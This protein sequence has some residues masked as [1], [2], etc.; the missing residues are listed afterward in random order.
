[1]RPR[2]ILALALLLVAQEAAAEP[3]IE[4]FQVA[5]QERDLLI[6]L[7]LVDGISADLL[8]RIQ[9]G[10]P[11]GI[12]YRIRLYRDHQRWFDDGLDSV[13]LETVAMYNAVTGEY[14]VNTK[15]GGKLLESRLVRDTEELV[16][17]LTRLEGIHVLT[18]DEEIPHEWRLLLR[19]RAE[20]GTRTVLAFIPQRIAS[21]W[22]RSRKFRA[23][24]PA[25]P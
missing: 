2:T 23:P 14:L 22:A 10:L 25:E 24:A 9:A 4:R 5:L 18:L 11:T 8:D 21:P 7:E 3:R 19:A 13:D 20:V 16:A 15:R 6:S 1:M 17:A 12:L